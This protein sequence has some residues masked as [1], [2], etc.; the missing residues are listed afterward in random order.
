M[1][2][3]RVRLTVRRMMLVV[4]A[5]GLTLAMARRVFVADWPDQLLLS[6]CFGDGTVYAK[7]YDESR[8]RAIRIGMTASQ[9]E[10]LVGP[11]LPRPSWWPEDDVWFYT[12]F[13]QQ[14]TSH[15]MRRVVFRDGKVVEVINAFYVD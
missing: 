14:R 8:F 1:R 3:P 7:G 4:A 10:M 2:F 6:I 11:P 9:V 5:L 13:S 12:F 15:R